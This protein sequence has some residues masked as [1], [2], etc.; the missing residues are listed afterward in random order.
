M[1]PLIIEPV[2]QKNVGDCVLASLSMIFG[3]PYQEVSTVALSHY[4][5]CAHQGLS[6]RQTMVIVKALGRTLQSIK[7]PDAHT[8]EGETGL[9]DIRMGRLYHTVVLFQG[10]VL[11]PADGLVYDLD[12]FLASRH[13]IPTRFFRP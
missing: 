1:G 12:T 2:V 9:L 3:I 10:V 7:V 4:P 13:A 5:D 11:N 6:T 8:L